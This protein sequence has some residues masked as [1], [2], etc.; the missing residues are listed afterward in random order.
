MITALLLLELSALGQDAAKDPLPER[1]YWLEVAKAHIAECR[2]TS[3]ESPPREFK[4]HPEPIFHHI[5]NTRGKSVGS[6]F[7]FVDKR[8]R[9][10]AVGDVFLFPR[11]KQHQL[12]NEWH[13][14]AAAPLEVKWNEETLM[15]SS[16][17][18]LKWNP[19]F[20]APAPAASKSQRER[21]VRQLARRFTAHLKD[22]AGEKYEL[23]LLTTPLY[24]Y[25][26]ED[27]E[28]E[29]AEQLGGG[30]FAFCQETDPEI[31]L[32]LE[33]QQTSAGPRWMFAAAEFSN[34]NLFLNLDDKESWSAN[35]PH[36]S[37]TGPHVGGKLKDVEL[38]APPRPK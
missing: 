23:R 11:G 38:V 20:D 37:S 33:V 25:H 14:L 19:V 12:Y 4:L 8:G 36:F 6:V 13:S 34:M 35:P 24:Q 32:L 16:E 22:S 10:A 3:K 17:P 21:Q 30:L 28:A 26:V 27:Q 18:G 5:Q 29:R 15:T 31:F 9:P 2:V 7:L 1:P